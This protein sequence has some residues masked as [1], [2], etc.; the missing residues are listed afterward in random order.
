MCDAV[1]QSRSCKDFL[2]FLRS[3]K[4]GVVVLS[5]FAGAAEELK[6]GALLVN[7]H[8][9]DQVA[10][11]LQM[12]LRMEGGEQCRRMENM[13]SH[14]RLHDVF[15]WFRSIDADTPICFPSPLMKSA[16]SILD[17]FAGL[18]T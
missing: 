9:T 17:R 3:D 13:R 8:D 15:R 7:P 18:P 5:E 12:A 1:F 16:P 14:I 4:H 2:F 10:H 6:F 11:V